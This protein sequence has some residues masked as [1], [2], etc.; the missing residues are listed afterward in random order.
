MIFLVLMR[1]FY[2]AFCNLKRTQF[3]TNVIGVKRKPMVLSSFAESFCYNVTLNSS[4]IKYFTLLIIVFVHRVFL[5]S[6]KCYTKFSMIN[7]PEF[8]M[9]IDY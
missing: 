5:H 4:F 7:L 1:F 6:L 8:D 3:V 9:I 2:F